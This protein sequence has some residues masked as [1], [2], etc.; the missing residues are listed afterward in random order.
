M[1]RAGALILQ[2][3]KWRLQRNSGYAKNRV[4]DTMVLVHQVLIGAGG[5]KADAQVVL[6]SFLKQTSATFYMNLRFAKLVSRIS[7]I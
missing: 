3:L 7:W 1:A 4:R 5:L 2:V 6:V